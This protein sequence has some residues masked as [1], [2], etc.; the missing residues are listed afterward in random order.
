MMVLMF[1]IAGTVE[2]TCDRSLDVFDEPIHIQEK[3]ILKFGEKAEILSDDIEKA[4]M[5]KEQEELLKEKEQERKRLEDQIL[6]LTNK[7]KEESQIRS[8]FEE[9]LSG[10]KSDF[11][12][13]KVEKSEKDGKVMELE[14]KLKEMEKREKEWENIKETLTTSIKSLKESEE[15]TRQEIALRK[16][17]DVEEQKKRN[18]I[19]NKGYF[20]SYHKF[21]TIAKNCR[22]F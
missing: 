12:T 8:E 17:A 13:L 3:L 5:L 2:L 15:A 10:L 16:Q 9:R 1:D 19:L 21:T 18:A 22:P 4:E 14:L 6:S 20:E 7:L 11:T